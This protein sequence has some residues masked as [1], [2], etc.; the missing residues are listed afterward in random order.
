MADGVGGFGVVPSRA[1]LERCFLLDDRDRVLVAKRRGDAS[2]LGF[3]VQLGTVRFL[4]SFLPDPTDVPVDVIDFVAGQVGVADASCVKGYLARRSTRFD[5]AAEITAEFGYRDFADV[6]G[7]LAVWLDDRAWTTGDGPLALSAAAIGWLRERLVL[8][9]GPSRVHRLVARV[10]DSATR[11]LW[12]V[13]AGMVSPLQAAE[14]DRLLDVADGSRVSELERLRSGPTTVSAVAMVAGLDRAATVAAFGLDRLD[15]G[16]VPRRR[17]VEL[18]RWGLTGHAPRLR[19]HPRARRAATL[20]ATVVFLQARAIDDALEVFDLLMVNELLAK[21]QRRSK[22]DSVREYPR[23]S[24]HAAQCAAAV[25]ML[26]AAGDDTTVAELWL[27]IDEVVPRANLVAAVA[28]IELL[29]PPVDTDPGGEWRVGLIDRYATVRRFVPRMCAVI[30]FAATADAA[31]VLEAFR[32]LPALFDARAHRTPGGWIDVSL[33]T[34]DVVPAGWW[35]QLVAPAPRP[36]GTVHRAAYVFCV[37]EQFHQRLRRGDIFATGSSRWADPRAQLMT[38][39]VWEQARGLVLNALELPAEPGGRLADHASHLDRAWRQITSRVDD[40]ASCV[41]VDADGR[42]HTTAL[43]AVED[44]ASLVWL[45]DRCEAMLPKID[46]GELILEVMRWHPSVVDAFTAVS[47]GDV[48]LVDLHVTIAAVLTAHA[49][50][51][52]YTPV[53]SPSMRALT[54]PGSATSTR[55]TCGPK[56]SAPRTDR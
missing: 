7:D 5:H 50:N 31:A 41:S 26:F 24:R 54:E 6:E 14:L 19:R 38:G 2:R 34:L 52:G 55:T 39:P 30:E 18:A 1:E 36:N 25:S 32:R 11:R 44:P 46:V 21:A 48:R 45:R 42:L 3:A 23:L 15:L 56:R 16:G 22:L 9:P 4:G 51:I 53:I 8:L 33:V 49:L 17:I 47:T 29:A 27:M 37:L 12:D 35:Q 43:D 10:R 40:N 28:N 13:L 20:V